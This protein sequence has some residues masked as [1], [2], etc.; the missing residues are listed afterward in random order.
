MAAQAEGLKTGDI[1]RIIGNAR[2]R[3]GAPKPYGA[4]RMGRLIVTN[5]ALRT[6]RITAGRDMMRYNCRIAS[7]ISVRTGNLSPLS[8]HVRMT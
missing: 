4:R 5:L 1:G 6:V 7:E 8:Q 2:T 3:I